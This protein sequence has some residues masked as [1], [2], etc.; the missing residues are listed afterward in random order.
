MRLVDTHCHLDFDR[1]DPDRDEV[2]ARARAAGVVRIIIPCLDLASCERALALADRYPEVRV[3]VGFHPNSLPPAPPLA[4]PEL[5]AIREMAG[6]PAVVAIGEI[7]LDYYWDKASPQHQ[8]DW[9][10]AQLALAADLNLPVIIHNRDATA[11]TLTELRRWRASLEGSLADAPGV[12]HSFAGD[13]ADAAQ[14]IDLGFC[15]GFTGPVTYPKADE[16]R[17]VAASIPLNR[18]LI[19]TDGPFLT[20]AP[21]RGKRNEPAY[22]RLIADRIA[23]LRDL[24]LEVLANAST[25]NAFRLFR[26]GFST[27]LT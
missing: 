20:P 14:A 1:Y 3:A 8:S 23:S 12:L 17:A 7:G 26:L 19:E 15:L 21:H 11:D 13:R 9:F 16:T 6:H 18:L 5:T 4:S 27:D 24:P 2:L 10:A 25:E 22:V